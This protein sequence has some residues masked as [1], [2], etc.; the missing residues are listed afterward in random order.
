MSFGS[1]TLYN[2]KEFLDFPMLENISFN[3]YFVSFFFF[4]PPPPNPT[5]RFPWDLNLRSTT[6]LS[7]NPELGYIVAHMIIE[8]IGIYKIDE[9]LRILTKFHENVQS[10]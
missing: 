7:P 4:Y 6:E 5:P 9:K 8:K 3:K 1:R 10:Y 2:N